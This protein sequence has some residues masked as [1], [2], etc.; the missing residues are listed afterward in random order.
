MATATLDL[1]CGASVTAQACTMT[2]GAILRLWSFE[3]GERSLKCFK[4]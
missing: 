1:G 4:L 3:A 2:A